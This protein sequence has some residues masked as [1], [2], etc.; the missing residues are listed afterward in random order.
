MGN[1]DNYG[2]LTSVTGSVGGGSGTYAGDRGILFPEFNQWA[3]GNQAILKI[4]TRAS[5]DDKN[6]I[7]ETI[8]IDVIFPDGLWRPSSTII[9]NGNLPKRG[10]EHPTIALCYLRDLTVNN[11]N[12]RPDHFRAVLSYKFRDVDDAGSLGGGGSEGEQTP[13]NTPFLIDYTPQITNSLVKNDLDGVIFS[14][15]N[16]EPYEFY[17]S[18]VRLDGLCRWNQYDWDQTEAEKWS[19]V[20]NSDTW[21]VGNYKFAK[22]TV[23]LSYVVGNLKFYVNNSGQRVPYY[24]MTAGISVK[25][26]GWGIGE[27]KIQQQRLGSFYYATPNVKI[28]KLPKDLSSGR[29]E[30]DLAT[31]GTLYSKNENEPLVQP[32]L[33]A[34]FDTFR[35]YQSLKFNFVDI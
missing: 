23:L 31:D 25:N 5:A 18:K 24:E 34:N 33:P 6:G 35:I 28:D 20:I 26:D 9:A 7:S 27:G 15:P 2:G 30:Y 16:A 3:E 11:Y 4:G 29:V 13:L 17:T 10:D 21:E 14:N 1:Q 12:G 19:N 8:T 22:E 32:L